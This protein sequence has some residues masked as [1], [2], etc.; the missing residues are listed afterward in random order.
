M[1]RI[2]AGWRRVGRKAF[3]R[4]ATFLITAAAILATALAQSAFAADTAN[5]AAKADGSKPERA[6][7]GTIVDHEGRPVASARIFWRLHDWLGLLTASAKTDSSGQ[8]RIPQPAVGKGNGIFGPGWLWIVTPQKQLSVFPV[9]KDALRPDAQPLRLKLP[10]PAALQ[11]TVRDPEGKPLAGAKVSPSWRVTP[12][13]EGNRATQPVPDVVASLVAETTNEHGIVVFPGVNPCETEG[14][15]VTTPQSGQQDC[16]Y[17]E[18]SE[19]T[20]ARE[21]T[22]RPV[23]RVKGRL[24]AD[25][26]EAVRGRKIEVSAWPATENRS[27]TVLGTAEVVTD[28][29]GRFEVA[30]I[31]EGKV[32]FEVR[33]SP[34]DRYLPAKF[35]SE[36]GLLAAGCEI[37]VELPLERG[38]RVHGVI[39]ESGSGKPLPDIGVAY[40]IPEGEHGIRLFTVFPNADGRFEFFWLR[41]W[42]PTSERGIA[43]RPIPREG[44]RRTF[45]W[46]DAYL[47]GLNTTP[48][49]KELEVPPIEMAQI[50]GRVVSAAGK[51]IACA[52]IQSV[53]VED[54]TESPGRTGGPYANQVQRGLKTDDAGRF[55]AW[56]NPNQRLRLTITSPG[57][58]AHETDWIQLP[59]SPSI[60]LPDVVMTP[61]RFRA[62]AGRVIDRQGKP[63]G[64]AKVFQTL[65]GPKP[66]EATTDAEGRFRLEGVSEESALVFVEKDGWRLSGHVVDGTPASLELVAV[67][68]SEPPRRTLKTLPLPRPRAERLTLARQALEAMLKSPDFKQGG[69]RDLITTFARIDPEQASQ[70]AAKEPKEVQAELLVSIAMAT[71][72]PPSM[73]MIHAVADPMDRV[74]LAARASTDSRLP[75]EKTLELLE[76]AADQ[77]RTMPVPEAEC[78]PMA[79]AMIAERLFR[80]GARETA[81]KLLHEA[82]AMV[83]PSSEPGDECSV[84]GVVATRLALVDLPAALK[85]IKSVQGEDVVGVH[86]ANVAGLLADHAPAEAERVFGMIPQ[87]DDGTF[88]RS[89]AAIL[90]CGRMAGVDLARARKIAGAVTKPEWSASLYGAM[91]RTLAKKQPAE[92]AALLQQA[93]GALSKAWASQPAG[94][95]DQSELVNIAAALVYVAEEVDPRL[96]EEHLWRC[97]SMCQPLVFDTPPSSNGMPLAD[98][99]PL[100]ATAALVASR[101]D[102]ALGERLGR[103]VQTQVKSGSRAWEDETFGLLML[104]LDPEQALAELDRSTNQQARTFIRPQRIELLARTDEAFWERVKRDAIRHLTLD[105]LDG[106]FNDD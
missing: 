42:R 29:Q 81:A 12:D 97:V 86:L 16:W 100:L 30:V 95:V 43:L 15:R 71:G 27:S 41:G 13:A 33:S 34:H 37:N 4:H 20:P 39:R 59:H 47:S 92:A 74:F 26:P 57:M 28:E 89:G 44:D 98:Q 55:I 101:Y 91:A 84:W 10:Q 83:K 9:S 40:H 69:R 54:R 38:I 78:R 73:E 88:D 52:T 75:K 14:L 82:Q 60:Q 67:R 77:V 76:K 1:G 94:A 50:Q 23:G 61:F 11:V 21:I 48:D 87:R 64:G 32:S 99:T 58:V 68:A 22:L 85:M 5:T 105:Y 80:L 17:G 19:K 51:S 36:A 6:I 46:G 65:S 90:V 96:V 62:V 93:S 18:P 49:R 66:T 25:S 2:A 31:A 104:V 103:A 53:F 56:V 8:F 24:A 7:A 63:V 106:W 79:M 3:G 35:R 45:F 72:S 102:R 70:L